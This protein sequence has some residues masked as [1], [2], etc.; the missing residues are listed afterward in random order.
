MARISGFH[1]GGPGS[2]PGSGAFLFFIFKTDDAQIWPKIKHDAI[3]LKNYPL[4][5]VPGYKP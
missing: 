3:I 5:L 2:I 1:P 4:L